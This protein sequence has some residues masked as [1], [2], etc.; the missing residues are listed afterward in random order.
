MKEVTD[1]PPN[2]A[3]TTYLTRPESADFLTSNGYP[4]AKGTLQKLACIGGGPIYRTFGIRALYKPDDLLAW[5][6]SRLSAPR[7]NTSEKGRPA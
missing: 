4:T 1:T 5:A 7:S 6:E 2:E 3:K